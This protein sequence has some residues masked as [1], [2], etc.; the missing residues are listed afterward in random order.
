MGYIYPKEIQKRIH[1]IED[2]KV[3]LGYNKPDERR[4]NGEKWTDKDGKMW[5]KK[6]GIIQSIPKFQDVRIPLF[7]PKCNSIMGKRSKDTDVFYK[8]GFCLDCLLERDIEMQKNGKWEQYQKTYIKDKKL[9]FY[10]DSKLEL[11]EYLKSFEKGYIEYVNKDGHM[12][13]W[14]G[15]DFDKMKEFWSKELKFIDEQLELLEKEKK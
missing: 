2:K 13:K 14:V 11:E 3:Q 9:G 10:K 12:E 15:A 1:G 7:C 8:F 6:D 4:E 5:E